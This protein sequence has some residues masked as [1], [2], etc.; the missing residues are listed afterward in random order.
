[1]MTKLVLL[2]KHRDEIFYKT[3]DRFIEIL[4]EIFLKVDLCDNLNFY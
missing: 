4:I 2:T 1:M 3:I